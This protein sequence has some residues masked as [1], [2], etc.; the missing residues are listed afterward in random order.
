[1]YWSFFG[2]N[3]ISFVG[4]PR[5]IASMEGK[6]TGGEPL[7]PV[8]EQTRNEVVQLAG[9]GPEIYSVHGQHQTRGS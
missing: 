2:G 8:A 7:H 4:H 6:V 1:M 5:A 3:E 9:D